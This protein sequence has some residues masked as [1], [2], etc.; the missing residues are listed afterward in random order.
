MV[1]L[2][3]LLA[4]TA[5]DAGPWA[6]APGLLEKATDPAFHAVASAEE[7]LRRRFDDPSPRT[8]EYAPP[9][10]D[11][12]RWFG[13][14]IPVLDPAPLGTLWYAGFGN[15][16]GD[17]GFRESTIE[18]TPQSDNRNPALGASISVPVARGVDAAL[19]FDQVDHFSDRMKYV[20]R[21]LLGWPDF[22]GAP[23]EV[24]R[25]YFGENIP[26]HSLL[27]GSLTI[28]DHGAVSARD[29]WIWLPSPGTGELQCWRATTAAGTLKFGTASWSHAEGWMDRADRVSGSAR[30]SQGRVSTGFVGD[31][32]FAWRTGLSYGATR[33]SGGTPWRPDESI[34]AQP[35]LDLAFSTGIVRLSGAHQ[36]G[37]DFFLFL[38][39]IRLS[40]DVGPA[41]V[42]LFASGRWTDRPDGSSPW[43]DS[44]TAGVVRMDSRALEQTYSTGAEMALHLGRFEAFASTTPWWI[45][46]PRAF[47]PD[48]FAIHTQA[49]DQEWIVRSGAERALDGVLWG[50]KSSLGANARIVDS[51]RVD[52]TLR[53]DPVLGGPAGQTDLVAPE[54]AASAGL[55]YG[56]RSGFSIHPVVVWRDE[57]ILR[58]RSAEDWVVPPGFDANLWIHQS[59]F[60][61]RLVFSMAALNI[62][63]ADRVQVP[64]AGEDRFR[65][66]VRVSGRVF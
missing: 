26:G 54:W 6:E 2:L 45:V 29:G 38:D 1:T 30:Q 34:S 17:Y 65:I 12:W 5:A 44:S 59:Y 24:R 11:G 50:W 27:A 21:S 55:R 42:G 19:A 46:H 18:E 56:H 20:R 51:V 36:A 57:T 58:H 31:S 14:S 10:S 39:T 63:A 8:D 7:I 35:S 61:E 52:A 33:T 48:S 53:H 3:A 49:L 28:R 22:D 13:R 37:T 40:R 66:L 4:A 64:N 32:T 15:E 16:V 60:R 23:S 47:A 43:T 9:R 41:H 25:A 62:L